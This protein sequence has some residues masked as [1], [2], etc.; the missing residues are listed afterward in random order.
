MTQN[1]DYA[2]LLATI[3]GLY[4]SFTGLWPLL[5]MRSFL[6]VTG[7]KTDLWLVET[8]GILVF[9]IGLGLLAAG[10]RQQISLSMGI[11]AVGTSSGL[12]L[13]D[14]LYFWAGVI[15]AI[16]LLDALLEVILLVAWIIY[17]YRVNMWRE[18]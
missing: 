4:F 10:Y 12:L 17:I 2:R 6:S 1:K 7:P 3:H 14:I 16:Y 5:H 18:M 15:S 13:I 11:I 9:F 8:V